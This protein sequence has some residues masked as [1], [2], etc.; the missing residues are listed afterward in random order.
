[1]ELWAATGGLQKQVHVREWDE[2]L[3]D[4]TLDVSWREQALLHP[5]LVYRLFRNVW[6]GALALRD[7]LDRAAY[8]PW[9]PPSDGAFVGDLPGEFTA[10]RFYFRES[11]P[12][13]PANRA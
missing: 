5:M 13:T 12:D 1:L 6:Q 10:V 11:F 2:Q 4:A 7:F 3:L 9:P 8:P